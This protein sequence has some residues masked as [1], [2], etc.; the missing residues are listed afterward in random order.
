MI[1]KA[2][3]IDFSLFIEDESTK[4]KEIKTKYDR[5][6]LGLLHLSGLLLI[7]I[8]TILIWTNKKNKVE[9][10]KN[11]FNDIIGLQLTIW[12]I[13][14]IPGIGINYFLSINDFINRAHY[15]IL[16]GVIIGALFSIMNTIN[17]MNNRPYKRFSFIKWKNKD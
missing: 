1:A 15:L 14:I 5:F 4:D 17:V 8:P 9:G 16:I 13:S 11:H 7:F 2:L 12:F 3:N 10:I 6:I